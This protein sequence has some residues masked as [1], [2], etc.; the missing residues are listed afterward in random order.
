MESIRKRYFINGEPVPAHAEHAHYLKPAAKLL[1][2]VRAQAGDTLSQH[3]QRMTLEDGARIEAHLRHGQAEI[4]IDLPQHLVA[5]EQSA[6]RGAYCVWEGN[7]EQY[8]KIV[9]WQMSSAVMDATGRF[10]YARGDDEEVPNNAELHPERRPGTGTVY[11]FD[12]AT[13]ALVG[14]FKHDSS[15]TLNLSEVSVDV[16]T[17]VFTAPFAPSLDVPHA[18]ARWA[19]G[20]LA[21]QQIPVADSRVYGLVNGGQ[22]SSG[23]GYCWTLAQ[24]ELRP[25]AQGSVPW[26]LEVYDA[27]ALTLVGALQ[28]NSQ[29]NRISVDATPRAGVVAAVHVNQA[30]EFTQVVA[31]RGESL[32][33]PAFSLHEAVVSFAFVLDNAADSAWLSLAESPNEFGADYTVTLYRYRS[34]TG[35]QRVDIDGLDQPWPFDLGDGLPYNVGKLVVH[36]PITDAVAFLMPDASAVHVF[37]GKDCFGDP[38]PP[39]KVELHPPDPVYV[40]RAT[41]LQRGVL[42][43]ETASFIYPYPHYTTIGKARLGR[44][45][46][47]KIDA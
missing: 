17:N 25:G 45:F 35:W 24:R 15:V 14:T 6:R 33:P 27:V 1:D 16:R 10:L 23:A 5:G 29:N 18:F 42:I 11:C 12:G 39:F 3:L 9:D 43:F 19:P 8:A 41:Q 28:I 4:H 37:N 7:T 26:F 46:Q 47:H 21:Y 2:Y 44:L 36:D 34:K 22:H 38:M 31:G 13:M 30:I 32:V 40:A 20:D